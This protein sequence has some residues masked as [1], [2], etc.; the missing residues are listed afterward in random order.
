MIFSRRLPHVVT[1][2]DLAVLLSPTYAAAQRVDEEVAQDRL[3]TALANDALLAQLYEG[4]SEALREYRGPRT[5][6]DALVDKLSHG[7][8]GRRAKVRP[9]SLTAA[10]SAVL[11]SIDLA[12]GIAPEMMRRTLDTEKGRALL[13]EGLKQLGV[14]LLKELLR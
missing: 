5:T 9:A 3:Q 14:H 10:V 12:A 1:R 7:V 4:L 13:G 8:E 2:A 6:E 11:V